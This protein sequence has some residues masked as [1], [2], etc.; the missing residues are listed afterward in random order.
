MHCY[1]ELGYKLLKYLLAT[2]AL[3]RQWLMKLNKLWDKL[4]R[5]ALVTVAIEPVKE[6][7]KEN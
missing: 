7:T 1:D 3:F 4:L 5:A 6:S 2:K